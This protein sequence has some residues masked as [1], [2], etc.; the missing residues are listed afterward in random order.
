LSKR[1]K[2]SSLLLILALAI[3][4]SAFASNSIQY[5]ISKNEYTEIVAKIAQ[6]E[7]KGEDFSREVQFNID[8]D[9]LN[10]LFFDRS[11][12]EKRVLKK[13]IT[14][15]LL[16]QK[17][18][19]K[20][21]VISDD[22]AK[23]FVKDQLKLMDSVSNSD[24]NKENLLN[25]IKDLGYADLNAYMNDEKVLSAAKK[26]LAR[27]KLADSIFFTEPIVTDDEINQYIL[28]KSEQEKEILIYKDDLTFRSQVKEYLKQKKQMKQY[29]DY[30]NELLKKGH[31]E[32]YIPVEL[33]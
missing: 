31:Y 18:L 16:D 2:L 33:N 22:E 4:T 12:Y 24:V 1:I 21:I 17:V 11:V 13:L 29:S 8:A 26:I 10:N 27:K 6:T 20:N 7:I 28:D 25:Y 32:I 9:E 5:E 15:A 3:T 14:N 19:E 30:K 23:K